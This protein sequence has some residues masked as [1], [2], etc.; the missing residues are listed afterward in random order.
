M[1]AFF[2]KLDKQDRSTL[3][4]CYFAFLA[5][6]SLA[7]TLGSVMPDLKL[8]YGVTDTQ[9]GLFLAA[10]S[11]GNLIAALVSG[12]LPLWLGQ[13]RAI[14][15]T[16]I[17]GFLGYV[18]MLVSGNPL[19]LLL[20]FLCVGLGRGSM[21]SFNNRMSN[22]LTD[23]S[24]VSTNLLHACF[25]I[26]AILSPLVFLALRGIHWRV[27]LCF[28]LGVS[29]AAWL[30]YCRLR[31]RPEWERPAE[32]RGGAGLSFLR[33][34]SYLILAGMMF[35]YLCSEYAVN[36]WLVSYI[37]SREEFLAA[38]SGMGTTLTAFSQGMATLMWC[39]M[40][41]GRL[42][43]AALAPRV[44]QKR[45][46]FVCCCAIVGF[47]ALMLFSDGLPA[48]VIAVAGLGLS[49][50]GVCPMIYSDAA[51]FTN[52]YPMATSM[53]L[54]V[55]SVGGIF[56][57]ALV[58]TLAE[59]L[60]FAAGMGAILVTILVLFLFALLNLTVKTRLPETARTPE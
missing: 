42:A 23:G 20:A 25:A 32:A 50:S 31:L 58:G 1:W 12:M 2:S 35:F 41:L 3:R 24:P 14:V 55:G 36:G 30:G 22:L 17:L 21:T 44:G 47:Y 16:S 34:P 48:V 26:G 43:C 54:C 51:V 52:A 8:N 18:M 46:M 38:L 53:L 57:P 28:V 7:L 45:L 56:M 29:F 9:G 10:H 40:L 39:T 5:S 19:W 15:L 13:K 33:N 4:T 37:Q 6:G 60:G 59:R 11:A 27:G 49:M